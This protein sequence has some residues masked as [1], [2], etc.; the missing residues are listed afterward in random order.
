M[1]CLCKQITG[2][3]IELS[4]T[5]IGKHWIFENLDP[6]EINALS[7]E[8]LRKKAIRHLLILPRLVMVYS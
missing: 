8:A 7:H 4:P 5:C 1:T 3:E 6:I 2:D